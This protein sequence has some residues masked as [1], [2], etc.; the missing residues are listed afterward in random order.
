MCIKTRWTA[1]TDHIH[2]LKGVTHPKR[3]YFTFCEG[4]ELKTTRFLLLKLTELRHS[5]FLEFNSREKYEHL[6]NWTRWNKRDKVWSSANS[7]FSWSFRSRQSRHCRCCLQ[8]PW[9]VCPH[10]IL[11]KAE[12]QQLTVTKVDW[13]TRRG[14][15]LAFWRRKS[16]LL[17][18]AAVW[19]PSITN[20]FKKASKHVQ[21]TLWY[22]SLPS[23]DNDLGGGG[24]G[25]PTPGNTWWGCAARFS[26]SWPY[27][28]PKILHTRFQSRPLRNC[29][30]ITWV[31]TS[32]KKIRSL[33]YSFGIHSE[34]INTFIHSCP[35]VFLENHALFQT[36]MGKVWPHIPVFRLKQRK[37]HTLWGGT[38]LSWLQH[39]EVPPWRRQLEMA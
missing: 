26:I 28:R 35:I 36:K 9:N 29:V 7:L 21:H 11:K 1:T 18:S 12:K 3:D 16:L 2:A 27:F 8:A 13:N 10:V 34:T 19:N 6:T 14:V 25:R 39:E 5:F 23:V 33:S 37:N 24:G 22:I 30:I 4:R 31:R 32:T 15:S 20:N 17:A 38:Y